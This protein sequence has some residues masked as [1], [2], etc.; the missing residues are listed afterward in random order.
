MS[1]NLVII[2]PWVALAAGVLILAFPRLLNV[3]VAIYL[4]IIGLT[5]L[6]GH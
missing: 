5:G 2:Q 3:L 1:F 6:V 4:I